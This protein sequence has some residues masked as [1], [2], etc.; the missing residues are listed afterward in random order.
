[1]GATPSD[2][3]AA[4]ESDPHAP[5]HLARE[6]DQ[7]QG[8]S[9]SPS[10]T[11][12]SKLVSLMK[13]GVRGVIQTTLGADRIK[14]SAGSGAARRRRGVLAP[15]TG[16]GE[17]R[18]GPVDF[19]ARWEGRRGRVCVNVV[20]GAG[21]CVAFSSESA[22]RHHLPLVKHEKEVKP[23]WSIPIGSITELRKVGGLG[24]KTRLV[25]GWALERGVA[26]GVEIRT[27]GGEV[28]CLTA[29]VGRDELF[30]RLVAMGRQR[31]VAF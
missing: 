2:L 10:P 9:A 26:D 19:E 31:W 1:M 18:E 23:L 17:V 12:N 20:A 28:V 27:R 4:L 14:A 21:A 11:G 15:R 6:S 7:A 3:A 5:E 25:V 22:T 8:K 13:K 16:R 30:N 24:W 29:M